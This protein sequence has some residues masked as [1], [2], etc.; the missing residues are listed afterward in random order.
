MPHAPDLE[1]LSLAAFMPP[2]IV[3]NAAEQVVVWNA[4]AERL[5]GWRAEQTIGRRLLDLDLNA[6]ASL[7]AE[8]LD[9]SESAVEQ[10]DLLVRAE[11][12]RFVPLLVSTSRMTAD[13]GTAVGAALVLTDL[14]RRTEAEA[15]LLATQERL[16]T[17]VRHSADFVALIDPAGTIEFLSASVRTVDGLT[18]GEMVG[19]NVFDFIHPDD[20]EKTRDVLGRVVGEDDAEL[21]VMFRCSNIAR[22]DRWLEGR[23]VNLLQRVNVGAVLVSLH[24]VTDRVEREASLAHDA[25]HDVLTGLA[26]RALFDN[27]LEHHVAHA[28]R[29]GLAVAAMFWDIDGFKSVN[30]LAGHAVGDSVLIE[31]AERARQILR[32]EDTVARIGGDEFVACA[33]VE[34]AEQARRLA[35]RLYERLHVDVVLADGR[36]LMV[37]PSIG[38]A[39]GV[40]VPAEQLL[41]EAD[42]AMYA[43]KHVDINGIK[44]CSVILDGRER[45]DDRAQ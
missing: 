8:A 2:T 24:D 20:T 29:H 38:L 32:D 36:R 11:D 10:R 6:L 12:G 3:T 19:R 39:C 14:T 15:V 31:M 16:Q 28:R 42:R 18:I 7:A 43:A 17:L 41:V 30:D 4:A 34:D 22:G 45:R 23:A 9:A 37:V 13:D 33:E 40:D 25:T 44:V 27:V 1:R 21:D 26:N 35:E 5:L